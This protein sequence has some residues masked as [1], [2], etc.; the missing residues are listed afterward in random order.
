MDKKLMERVQKLMK[1]STVKDNY[2]CP[3]CRDLGYTFEMGKD[4]NEIAV[5]CQCLSKKRAVENLKKCGLSDVFKKK[6]FESYKTLTTSQIA[7]KHKSLKYCKSDFQ[8][9]KSI[10]L[11]GRSGTGKTHLG[12]AIMLNLIEQGV[13]CRYVEYN[14]M[15]ISL[16][17]SVM[18]ELNHLKEMEKLLNPRVLF[19]DDFLKGK[20]TD[21]DLNYI[22]RIIN[23]RYLSNKQLIISTEKSMEEIL[24]WDEAVGSRLVEM[25]GENIIYFDENSLNYRLK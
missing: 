8:N 23:S 13:N 18:D 9:K 14:N 22:Y 5:P 11:S 6:T 15:I 4:N 7:A 3:K 16:K 21:S 25:A 24:S 1:E 2:D 10:I 19:I 12:I 20:T 17:Q